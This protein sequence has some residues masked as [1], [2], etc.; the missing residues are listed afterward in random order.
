MSS[1]TVIADIFFGLKFPIVDQIDFEK[2]KQIPNGTLV[3][4]NGNEGYI[5]IIE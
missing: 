1:G 2:L 3:H 5:E 4:V